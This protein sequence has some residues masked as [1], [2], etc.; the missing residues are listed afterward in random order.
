MSNKAIIPFFSAREINS[1]DMYERLYHTK[2]YFK[3]KSELI[4]DRMR[5]NPQIALLMK[6]CGYVNFTKFRAHRKEWDNIE[7][8]I[9]LS[10]LDAIGADLESIKEKVRID[11]DEYDRVIKIPLF[12]RF[13]TARLMACVYMDVKLPE[14]VSEGGAIEFL[15][16]IK[17]D[18]PIN[19]WICFPDIKT[20][21]VDKDGNVSHL[22]HRP[23][24]RFTRHWAMF[25][26]D[27]KNIGKVR[28]A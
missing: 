16:T 28:L 13:A 15:K 6:K 23:V 20:I 14:G 21:F 26:S 8:K 19:H 18:Y 27:S 25:S 1:I 9:P 22:F 3:D 5:P 10:Y 24:V 7:R 12:P 11:Q 4:P 2:M 17:S